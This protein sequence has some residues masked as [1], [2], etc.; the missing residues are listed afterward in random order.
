MEYLVHLN[1]SSCGISSVTNATFSKMI[2]LIVLDMSWNRLGSLASHLFESHRKLKTLKLSNN[3]GL[4]H[5]QPYVF[6]GLNLDSLDLSHNH[7]EKV[8]DDAFAALQSE[9]IYLNE[10]EIHIFSTD[11][12]NGIE[13]VGLLV[14]N[15][16]KFCCIKPYFLAEESCFPHATAI[17]SCDNL[18]Q[19][20]VIRPFAW[21]VGLTAI[22][23]NILAFIYRMYDKE[24][25]K[26][27]YGIFVSNLAISD[28]LMGV[29][30]III[31]SADVYYRGDYMMHDDAWRT[32][33]LCNFAGVI[34]TL[35]SET[36]VLCI[37]LV[38]LDRLLVVKFPFGN[39][40]LKEK[41]SWILVSIIWVLGLFISIFPL[42]FT[43]YFKG[44][45]YSR[46]SV[47]LALPLT[48]DRPAGWLYSVLIFVGLNCLVVVI[49]V[50]GQW[51]IFREV[52]TTAADTQPKCKKHRKRE[53]TIARNLLLVAMTDF[54][55]WFPVGVLGKIYKTLCFI[56]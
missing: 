52:I 36:S 34:A 31:A 3:Q 48:S 9:T 8:S 16:F 49:I 33:W 32:G 44:E 27:G 51:L 17:S 46:S 41:A 7:I 35:S 13:Y 28:F 38:S 40:R 39:V 12:F 37:C 47:C 50:L 5:I 56:K 29:Y 4:L 21:T 24:R 43:S 20:E 23:S 45:F 54:L 19:N 6:A 42:V 18:L 15:A 11:M 14:T 30:L 26:L 55:C 25:L 2:N 1:I 10:S 22:V 53:L